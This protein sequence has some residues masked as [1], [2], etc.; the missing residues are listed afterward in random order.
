VE[1]LEMELVQYSGSF[2]FADGEKLQRQLRDYQKYAKEYL[3]KIN[4]KVVDLSSPDKYHLSDDLWDFW[5]TYCLLIPDWYEVAAEVALVFT[6]SACVER[7]FSLYEDFFGDHDKACL[8]DRREAS[9]KLRF[10]QN[11]RGLGR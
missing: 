7:V 1:F 10:N 3:V 11:Q 8:E 4:R 6:S 5:K 9:I 2:P